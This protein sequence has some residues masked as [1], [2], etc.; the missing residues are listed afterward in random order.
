VHGA[1]G[2]HHVNRALV[3]NKV[4]VERP[5]FVLYERRPD[6]SYVM[7]AVEY[8]VP[9]R[10][11]PRDSVPP[12]VLGRDMLRNDPLNLWNLHMWV[13]SKNPAGLFAEW[14]PNVRCPASK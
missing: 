2:Y 9:Y 7:N 5:E 13:W 12:K 14:N 4:E 3:D 1:M 8:I 11:W 6:G 10:V